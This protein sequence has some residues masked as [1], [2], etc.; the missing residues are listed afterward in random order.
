M[1]EGEWTM[2][3]TVFWPVRL[4]YLCGTITPDPK[5]LDWRKDA[6]EYFRI[7]GIGVLSPV[8]GKDPSNWHKDGLEGNDDQV[9][10]H[11]GFVARDERDILRSDC[12][13]LYFS[14]AAKPGRQSIGTWA[15][16]GYAK[17]EGIPIVVAS[18]MPEVFGHPFVYR[19]ATRVCPTLDEAMKYVRFLLS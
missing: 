19:W 18:D 17:S 14:A 4:V 2:T 7:H 5:H 12:I 3:E 9:Y 8:R 13:L 11:G 16:M 15:E 6:E 10:S 1:A